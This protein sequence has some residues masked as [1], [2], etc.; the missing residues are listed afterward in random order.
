M[1]FAAT[2]IAMLS[3]PL[4]R[5]SARAMLR[6]G[7]AFAVAVLIFSAGF[8][9]IMSGV[10]GRQFT[11]PTA[12][13]WTLVTMTTLGFGD[14]VFESDVGR[15]Y[16]VVVL[17]TGAL[18]ILILLPFTFIQL[19]YLPWRAAVREARTPREAPE[20]TAG[21]VVLTGRSPMEQQ[22]MHRAAAVGVPSVLIVEDAAEAAGLHDEGYTV[23]FG[24]LDDPATYRAARAERAAMV[25]A[26]GSDQANTNIAFTVR[27]VTTGGVLVATASSRDA[28][29]VLDLAGV[30]HVLHLGDLLGQAFASRILAPTARGSVISQFDGLVI[31]EASAAGTVLVGRTLDE[32]ALREQC[33]I[34]IVGLWDRGSLFQAEPRARVEESSILLLAGTPSAVEAYN[35]AFG[36]DGSGPAR[37]DQHVVVL[38]GGRV[39]RATAAALAAADTPCVI[40][41]RHAERVQGF[42]NAV[43]GDAADRA[44]LR[45]AGIDRASAV[46]VTT[47]DDD[48][49]VYLTLYCRRLR[50]AAEI[51]GRV[52][53]D[54]NV[55]TMHRAG[56]DFALSYASLG[57]IQAWNAMEEQRTLLLAEGLVAF[58]TPVPP[59]LA[60]AAAAEV[61]E[62]G[63]ALV[64]VIRD[65]EAST[66]VASD[67]PLPADADLVLV[68]SPDAEERFYARYVT[69]GRAWGAATA[70]LLER[71]LG[72]GLRRLVRR[73]G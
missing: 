16:S 35:A 52:Q 47:H 69:G 59:H 58:R 64:G 48:T 1:K 18:L 33:G 67:M 73:V 31:A 6:L 43:V 5:G 21:H 11:W 19:V 8:Q 45:R 49:N 65:G 39:G 66:D 40:V 63:C 27:E 53:L 7:V 23:V 36:A 50:P 20:G 68:G 57:A 15:M 42:A 28:I 17:L 61:S 32:L 29:D 30:D 26:A 72:A 3:A 46:V 4:S 41:E 51:L 2:L 44:V 55:T 14:I 60:G 24:A 54:R 37:G 71:R 62:T 34:S 22:V 10:E 12:V 56:A 38:G 9:V 70:S 13:Y 25:L